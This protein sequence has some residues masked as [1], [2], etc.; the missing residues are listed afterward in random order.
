MDDAYCAGRIVQL[1]DDARS[2]AAIAAELGVSP[3]EAVDPPKVPKKEV[4]PL[5]PEQAVNSHKVDLRADIYSLGCTL[6]FLLTGK[7]L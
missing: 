3:A 4:T 7:T 5:S 6:Y 2:D 1:L